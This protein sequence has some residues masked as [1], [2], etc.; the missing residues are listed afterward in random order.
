MPED[1]GPEPTRPE[2]DGAA[3]AYD[4]DE[5]IAWY[6]AAA[7]GS[8]DEE[9]EEAPHGDENPAKA[10]LQDEGEEAKDDGDAPILASDPYLDAGD[11]DAAAVTDPYAAPS[12]PYEEIQSAP[13]GEATEPAAPPPGAAV[14]L[15]PPAPGA[16]AQGGVPGEPVIDLTSDAAR[17]GPERPRKVQKT[18]AHAQTRPPVPPFPPQDPPTKSRLPPTPPR[19]PSTPLPQQLPQMQ[20]DAAANAAAPSEPDASSMLDPSEYESELEFKE[21]VPQL[22][23]AADTGEVN[24][25]DF[26]WENSWDARV[27]VVR[28]GQVHIELQQRS[29]PMHD[30]ALM[31][32]CDWLDQQMPLVVQNF[33]YVKKSGAY[34]D[35]SDNAIGPDGLDKLF[36]VLR[37]HS[38]PCVVMKAYRN[39]LTDNIV[40]TIVEYLYTQPEAFPMHG[41]HISHNNITDKG[42]FRLIRAAALCGHYPR[43]TSRLPLWL[44]LEANHIENPHKIIT[45]CLAGEFNVCLMGD[46]LCSRPDCNHYSH[47]HVQLPYF[48]NQ[49][50]QARTGYQPVWEPM[51]VDDPAPVQ[52]MTEAPPPQASDGAAEPPADDPNEPVPDWKRTTPVNLQGVIAPK[53]A[54]AP[55]EVSLGATVLVRPAMPGPGGGPPGACGKATGSCKGLPGGGKG[56]APAA[57]Y[58]SGAGPFYGKGKGGPKGGGKAAFGP[59]CGGGAWKGDHPPGKGGAGRGGG[60][61]GRMW[62]GM[63]LMSKAKKEVKLAEGEPLGFDWR[64]VGEGHSPQVVFV[65]PRAKV[66]KVVFV[67]DCLLRVNCLDTSMFSEKQITDMLKARPLDVRFGD[68]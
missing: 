48:Y 22:E 32:F 49:S 13:Q 20:L 56:F 58:A 25:H 40:D 33:P 16:P 14:P 1:I 18:Q 65:D 28:Q 68:E 45:D 4:D 30:S 44:R 51:P 23:G 66:G 24:L 63:S 38:V 9:G 47:V 50:R 31:Q 11:L 60:W 59:P 19:A 3:T 52:P 41:I 42:A 36:R 67:G 10:E 26:D 39:L 61:R 17:P 57:K 29:P 2:G 64:F 54:G 55:P 12:D 53:R 8:S 21:P 7:I 37:D 34:V 15:A 5:G 62:Q 27:L 43:L 46:G 6:A 35:L